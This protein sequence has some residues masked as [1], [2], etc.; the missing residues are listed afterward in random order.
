MRARVDEEVLI[1]SYWVVW[2]KEIMT[3]NMAVAAENEW[4]DEKFTNGKWDRQDWDKGHKSVHENPRFQH[5]LLGG[6]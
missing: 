4:L 3:W 2:A 1:R 6:C 5:E